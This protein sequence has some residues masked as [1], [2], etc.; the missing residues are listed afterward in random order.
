[1]RRRAGD[2]AKDCGS[3]LPGRDRQRADACAVKAFKA[4]R[5]FFVRYYLQG[6]DSIVA[7]GMSG[8]AAGVVYLYNY[9]SDPSGRGNIGERVSERRCE[10]PKVVK[11][12]G[13]R[14]IRC[15]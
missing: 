10:K 1:M 2:G 6:I 14:R 3:V 8:D 13:V 7:D 4:K 15:E 11:E 12:K 5:P 9:D